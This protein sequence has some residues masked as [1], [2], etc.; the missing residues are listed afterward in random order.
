MFESRSRPSTDPLILWL[1]GGTFCSI[2]EKLAN[3]VLQDLDAQ[4]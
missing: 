2:E 3:N 1:T 4:V